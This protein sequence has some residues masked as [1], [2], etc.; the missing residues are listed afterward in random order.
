VQQKA[1]GH[2]IRKKGNGD[3]FM[4]TKAQFARR[5]LLRGAVLGVACLPVFPL[6]GWAEKQRG[7]TEPAAVPYPGSDDALLDEIE[8]NRV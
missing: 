3:G 5:N 1:N 6:V 8:R 2:L 4:R 7:F